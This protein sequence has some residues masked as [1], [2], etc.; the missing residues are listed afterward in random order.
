MPTRNLLQASETGEFD[1]DTTS[2]GSDFSS[3]EEDELSGSTPYDRTTNSDPSMALRSRNKLSLPEGYAPERVP[4]EVKLLPIPSCSPAHH[5]TMNK[6]TQPISARVFGNTFI[7]G[8]PQNAA[9]SSMDM[10]DL[11]HSVIVSKSGHRRGFSFAPG[12]DS[13]DSAPF[14]ETSE[15]S[16]RSQGTASTPLA[17]VADNGRPRDQSHESLGN[18][19]ISGSAL[20]SRPYRHLSEGFH[21]VSDLGESPKLPERYG[22]GKSVL[23]A[24]KGSSGGSP[25]LSHGGSMSSMVDNDVVMDSVKQKGDSHFFAIAAARAA[26]NVS[27]NFKPTQRQVRA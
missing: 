4:W 18:E 22:S 11:Q 19:S 20:K 5:S 17:V 2:A 10:D 16:I 8:K 21:S 15:I 14:K 27:L 12:D 1:D 23:T 26:K 13:T 7:A 24:F 25:S 3:D 6:V 9:Q